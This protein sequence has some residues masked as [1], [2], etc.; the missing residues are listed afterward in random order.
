MRLCDFAISN[1]PYQCADFLY[2]VPVKV[3][4]NTM[5]TAGDLVIDQMKMTIEGHVLGNATFEHCY[6]NL[7]GG[8]Q[9]AFIHG[10]GV[11]AVF[12]KTLTDALERIGQ[13]PLVSVRCTDFVDILL[14]VE[15]MLDGNVIAVDLE[16]AEISST[17]HGADWNLSV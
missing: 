1:T 9:S 7:D 3:R 17:D 11:I 14:D 8:M 10:C 5:P 4:G 12:G 6:K 13:N 15:I 16:T 2:T